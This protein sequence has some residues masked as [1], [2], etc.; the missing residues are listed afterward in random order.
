MLAPYEIKLMAMAVGTSASVVITGIVA[1]TVVKL[2]QTPRGAPNGLDGRSAAAEER[3][4]RIEQTLEALS[5][6]MERSSEAQRFTARLLAE[7]VGE[8]PARLP[9]R[10][11]GQ[12]RSNNTP[13]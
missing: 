9:E 10:A 12:Q 4:A 2:R 6:E 7:R 5:I 1:W 3:L 8:L 11:I 13:H